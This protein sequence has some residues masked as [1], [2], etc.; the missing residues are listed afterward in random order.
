MPSRD[1]Q[2]Y[3]RA[4][5]KLNEHRSPDCRTSREQRRHG[6]TRR[7]MNAGCDDDFDLPRQPVIAVFDHFLRFDGLHG[8]LVLDREGTRSRPVLNIASP[9]Q[10]DELG[11]ENEQQADQQE[12]SDSS[13][14]HRTHT[15]WEIT[16]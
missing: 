6:A 10:Q 14:D 8:E 4:E 9:T 1:L 11:G 12:P 7:A 5:E 2:E 13:H 3:G 16:L 15:S